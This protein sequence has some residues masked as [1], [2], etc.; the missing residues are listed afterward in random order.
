MHS[1]TKMA[2]VA[3]LEM[4][5]DR[6]AMVSMKARRTC[7]MERPNNFIMKNRRRLPKGILVMAIDSA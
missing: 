4:K 3:T 1:A 6:V 7:F 2:A 5:A